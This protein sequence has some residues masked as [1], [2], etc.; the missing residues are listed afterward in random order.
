MEICNDD[1]L[2]IGRAIPEDPLLLRNRQPA[3]SAFEG[4]LYL[5]SIKH[6]EAILRIFPDYDLA[7]EFVVAENKHS[8]S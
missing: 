3:Y 7:L 5:D 6:C 1:G 8:W 2:E 4:R